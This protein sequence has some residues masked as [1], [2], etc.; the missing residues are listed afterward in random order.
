MHFGERKWR[1]ETIKF[2]LKIG[3]NNQVNRDY[4]KSYEIISKVTL[5]ANEG[6]THRILQQTLFA[7]PEGLSTWA[8]SVAGGLSDRPRHLLAPRLHFPIW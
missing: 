7:E 3:I 6:L 2:L 1:N 8:I 4:S 5:V